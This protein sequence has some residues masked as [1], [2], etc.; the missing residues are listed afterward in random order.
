[1]SSARRFLV[2][3]AGTEDAA[4]PEQVARVVG[5]GGP[6]IEIML[7]HVAE[8]G[9]REL[10][11]HHPAI[12]RGPWPLPKEDLIERRLADADEKEGAA[13]LA[14]WHERFAATLPAAQIGQLIAQGRPEQEIVA[15]AVRLSADA[16]ILC[17]RPRAG[18]TAPGPASVG[19]VARFVLDHSSVP[20]LLIRR[21]S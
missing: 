10:T 12:R 1:M 15:V 9:P 16:V 7:L 5:A 14:V 6:E 20:V 19:H 11:T 17:A 8:T 4:L 13:L 21:T 3:L 18:P 2:A